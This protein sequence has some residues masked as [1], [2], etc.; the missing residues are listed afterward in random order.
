MR[1]GEPFRASELPEAATR[2][3]QAIAD[4]IMRRVAA[5]LPEEMRGYYSD[6]VHEP[7]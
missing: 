6:A 1:V 2:D 3:E 7:T 4:A 5:L